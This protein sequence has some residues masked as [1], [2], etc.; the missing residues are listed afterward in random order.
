M[1]LINIAMIVGLVLVGLFSHSLSVLAAGGD[2]IADS[3]AIVLGIL[4]VQLRD[5][6]G[7]RQA[8]TF[9]AL[10]N[11]LLL[12]GIT[13]LM[14]FQAGHRLSTQSPEVYGLPVLIVA[15]VSV[16]A[17]MTG[18]L[19]LGRG[20]GNEDLHM[21]SV[22]NDTISDGVSAAAVA[23]VGAIIFFTKGLYWLDAAT[24]ILISIVIGVG[25]IQL[26][27]EV[28]DALRR[29]TPVGKKVTKRLQ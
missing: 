12:L 16:V 7:K 20:A 17:M 14:L 25:A 29:G 22:F 27:G 2:F 23:V 5:K 13:V 3:L 26:L 19:I 9:V 28:I 8:P 4:A 1:L 21:R 18:A 6:H 24:A 11:A 10:V 15:A